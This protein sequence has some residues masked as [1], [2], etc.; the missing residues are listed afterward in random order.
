MNRLISLFFTLCLILT[1]F[2][3]NSP[4]TKKTEIVPDVGFGAYIYSY[5]S[6]TISKNSS[7]AIEFTK[8]SA[9]DISRG[10]EIDSE[11]FS[12]NPEVKGKAYWVNPKRIEFIPDDLLLSGT[13]YEVEVQLDKV[14]DVPEKFQ[15]FKF[16]FQTIQQTFRFYDNGLKT[17]GQ[18]GRNLMFYEGY[19]QTA[20]IMEPSEIEKVLSAEFDGKKQAV[21]WLHQGD[22]LLHKFRIDSL[23]REHDKIN[24][25][26]V[27]WNG[28]GIGIDV[29]GEKEVEIPAMDEFG[30]L[31]ISVNTSGEKYVVVRFTDQLDTKQNLEGLI[32]IENTKNLRFGIENNI[33]KIWGIE[34][35]TGEKEVRISK[36]IKNASQ[37][38]LSETETHSLVFENLKPAVR[39][40]GKGVIV[41][42]EGT[43][44]MPIEAVSLNAVE[45]RIIQ[46]YAQ[47]ISQFL[48]ENKLDGNDEIKKTGRLVYAGKVD[49]KPDNPID[50]L[51]WNT[52]KIGIQDLIDIEQGAV[53][54]VEIRF[55]KEYS[56]YYCGE[57][58]SENTS[59]ATI[60]TGQ[61]ELGKEQ[62][63][64][65]NPGWYSM[66]YYPKDFDW[67][68]RDDPCNVSYYYY[69][70]FVSRNIFASNLG[71]I[72]KEGKG[73]QMTYAVTDLLTTLP[74]SNV[75][76]SLYNYQNILLD[77]VTTN[78]NGIAV[79]DLTKKPFLLIAKKGNQIG[80][81]RLDDGT[82]LSMSNF[83]I[84][85]KK[86]QEG[87]KGFIYGERGVW[88]PGDQMYLT[89]I[90]EDEL[91]T[92]PQ[93]TPVIFKLINP[94]G[95]VVERIVR[96]EGHN[97]FYQFNVKTTEDA[98]TGNWRAKIEIGGVSF[99]KRIKVETVK[100]NRLK[101]ILPLPEIIESES[102]DVAKMNVQ[103]LHGAP[104]RSLKAKID[105]N[106]VAGSSG[107]DNY[108][109]YSFSDPASSFYPREDL[110][111]DGKLDEKGNVDVPLKINGTNQAPGILKAYFT[112]RVFEEGGDFSINVQSTQFAPFKNYVGIKLPKTNGNWY[113]NKTDYITKIV[114]VDAK[115][116]PVKIKNVEIELLKVGWRWWWESGNN[117]LAHYVR[118]SSRHRVGYWKVDELD[119]SYDFRLNVKY[120]NWDD[121]GRYLLRVKDTESGHCTGVTF[122]MSPWGGWRSRGSGEGATMLVVEAEKEKYKVGEKVKVAIP[123][124]KNGRALVSIESGSAIKDIFWVETSDNNTS[125][126]FEASS[127]MTPNVYVNVSLIQPYGQTEN[128]API[129]LYGVTSIEVEDPETILKPKLKM[130]DEVEPEQDYQIEVSEENGK[131]MTYTLA[132]VDEG[133]LDLTNFKTPDPHK[134]FYARQAL[135]VK[136]WD[137]F[138]YVAGAYG[139]ALEKA[140]AVGGDEGKLEGEK[141]KV[142]RFKPVVQFAGPFTL[143]KGEKKIHTFH[144]PNYVGSVKAMVVA[145]D[146]R[147]YGNAGQT[148]KVRK[149]LML[150]ATLPRVLGPGEEVKLPVSVF[151]MKENVKNVTVKVETSDIFEVVGDSQNKM[152]F[153]EIGDQLSYFT[154][155]VKEKLGAGKVKIHAKS[156]NEEAT[157]EIEI[158]IR[159]PNPPITVDQ[160]GIVKK[161]DVW[162][163]SL[164]A[165]GMEGTNEAWLEISGIPPLNLSRHLNYLIRYPHGCIEQT[166]SSVFPQL[167]LDKLTKLTTEQKM[168]VDKNIRIA[169]RKYMRFQTSDGGFGY[170][171]GNSY[172]NEWGSCYAGHFM[173]LAEQ[174][175]HQIPAG[176]KRRWLNYQRN[177]AQNWK[178]KSTYQNG[179]Y[180][181]GD[182]LIQSYRLY[183]LALSGEPDFGAMNRFAEQYKSNTSKWRL[184]AA[185]LLAGQDEAGKKVLKGLNYT[186]EDYRE[187]GGTYGSSLRDRAMILETLIL[188]KNTEDA[189]LVL[190]EISEELSKATWLST[191][192]AAWCFYAAARFVEHNENSPEIKL[193]ATVNGENREFIVSEPVMK[194]PIQFSSDGKL[195]VVVDNNGDNLFYARIVATGIPFKGDT[196]NISKHLNLKV[197]YTDIAGNVI[198]PKKLAQ[199]TDLTMNVKVG[200]PGTRGTYEE[201]ALTCIVPSGW[202]ILN[203]RLNDVPGSDK[204]GFDFQDIRDDR[205]YTYFD[206]GRGREKTFSFQLNAAYEGRF[207]LPA[208]TCE[209]MYDNTVSAR[210]SGTWVEIGN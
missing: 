41:P 40:V 56:L 184:A 121:Y 110:F 14:M 36:G 89:F 115:G 1:L 64:W 38:E 59:Q 152:E 60:Q 91:N 79:I 102:K 67:G 200:H 203:K 187:M 125:F 51:R 197:W 17:Y 97:G 168:D 141:K 86:V 25:L 112:T 144:M 50:L 3:C 15:Q 147:A 124:S 77:K 167:Y 163:A 8:A 62:K 34:Q 111:F 210:V 22:M 106:L 99:E 81:L 156:G 136:T 173:V 52:Y 192:T 118:N 126:E 96:T 117:G 48:Q 150:L 155:K 207:Y 201:I 5:T 174:A 27:E 39:L 100:P 146:N 35:V 28:K 63:Q 12:L 49:L 87:L 74:I 26:A 78:T 149:G 178:N 202:E 195:K 119:K 148:M 68:Y 42:Q 196:S 93:N 172:S 160:D 129:R 88:R 134:S 179:H 170:W 205:I 190:K 32:T 140:F 54:R 84:S 143:K 37:Y 45:V 120:D 53:Y 180:V 94:K 2:S 158:E 80:Y 154:L 33:V 159:N 46:I 21:T 75:E 169:L 76:L 113:K 9:N 114:A 43:L 131:K 92:L 83:N 191:Q 107:F 142:N 127:D 31:D 171:P 18:Q 153:N 189:F 181:G 132:V 109:G 104:A 128:D 139:A 101:I 90:L 186:V 206:L 23:V 157:Y 176:M 70:R 13:R 183:T 10:D 165:P 198:D 98:P 29:K 20:D 145:G 65:D 16:S 24:T 11:L 182:E 188:S 135:G 71:I 95:Q 208:V 194:Y 57:K 175:G 177:K 193:Q 133:L 122:Y 204:S 116:N 108:P 166:T 162:N 209:P 72:A 30:V 55:H 69:D 130:D 19:F 85:G 137:M 58:E 185:Y 138:D 103:W 82:A 105:L 123:S 151:A 66:Y 44:F 6:G 73:Y 199:G 4:K 61:S 7:L 161:G 164:D 47:N